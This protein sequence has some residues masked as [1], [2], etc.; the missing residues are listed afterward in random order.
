MKQKCAI[1]IDMD[2]V[3]N[4]YK[5][6]KLDPPSHVRLNAVYDE[7]L[8]RFL[9]IFDR[10]E[11]KATFFIVGLDAKRNKKKIRQ[12]HERGHEIANHTYSHKSDFIQLS[13]KEKEYEISEADKI[14]SDIA[15]SKIVGFRS[16]GWG[17][18][19]IT[20]DILEKLNYK[21]DSSGF[22]SLLIVGISGADWI[23]MRGKQ[24][25]N[26]KNSWS[27]KMGLAP[28]LPYF[29]D[30]KDYSKRGNRKVLEIPLTILPYFNLPFI[31]TLVF[32]FGKRYFNLFLWYFSKF[33]RSLIYILHGIELV[34][35]YLIND[36]N[37]K[38]TGLRLSVQKK[39]EIYN[40]I[41]SSVI[42]NRY[43]FIQMKDYKIL[44]RY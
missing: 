2:E 21:Y 20:L 6:R 31:N 7:A 9:D 30:Y 18:D 13:S 16:P 42:R 32:M 28:K 41:F 35:Y 39:N 38:K 1:S 36:K 19:N 12:I 29:P 5:L 8:P 26:L 15:G 37:L 3:Y 44:N 25:F 14:L 23:L 11:I 43:S 27:F 40:H 10:F 4:Y 22:P 33:D 24:E 17:I 34:D